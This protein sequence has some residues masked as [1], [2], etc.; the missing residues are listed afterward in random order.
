[1]LCRVVQSFGINMSLSK[2]KVILRI[3]FYFNIQRTAESEKKDKDIV[4]YS[5]GKKKGSV[6]RPN[7]MHSL[8]L[9]WPMGADTKS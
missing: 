2:R 8:S 3:N 6:E 4:E 7:R 9:P 1:M 5:C